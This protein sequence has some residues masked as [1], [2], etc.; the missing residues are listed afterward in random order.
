MRSWNNSIISLPSIRRR[1]D[2]TAKETVPEAGWRSLRLRLLLWIVI[3]LIPAAILSVLHGLDRV[4]RDVADVHERMI[5]MSSAAASD[6][7]S[8]FLSAEQ[9]LRALANQTEVRDAT[10]ACAKSLS[11]ALRGLAYYTNIVRMD[12]A[13]H[14]L[15]TAAPQ[16]RGRA[17][18]SDRTWWQQ[19][20]RSTAFFITPQIYSPIAKRDVLAGVLPLSSAGGMSDGVLV[21]ALDSSWLDA[22]LH[23]KPV[24]DGAVVALFDRTG[25]MVA[26]NDH[27]EAASLFGARISPNRGAQ[28][29]QPARDRQ[30]HG[31]SYTVA[32]LL[33]DNSYLGFAMPN[34]QL[35]ASTYL[36]VA[37]DLFLPVLM[38]GAA[39]IA[40]WIAADR[41]VTRWIVYLRRIATAYAHGHYG[42]RPNALEKAP[43]EF[44][45][46]GES[47]SGMAE[48]VQD[49]DRRLRE[50]LAQKTLLIRETHHRVKNNLQIVMSLLSLQA[51]QLRDPAAQNALRQAQV[52]VNALALVHRILHEIE[53]L[54][55][56]DLKRLIQDL[57]RQIHEGFG[58]E[59]RDLKLELDLASL[60]V[61]GD[62]AVPITLFTVE[63]LTNA[64]KHAYPVGS[65]GGTIRV[66]LRPAPDRKLRLMV[67]DDGTGV[68]REP[69]GSGIGSRL[70]QAF[71]SQVGGQASVSARDGGGTVVALV[72]PD[73]LSS[74]QAAETVAAV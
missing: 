28:S 32:P 3:A 36:H 67:E 2:L 46:L 20:L 71:A 18:L 66:S 43:E 22:M 19:A 29:V 27:D 68:E 1:K 25:T 4:R 51:G 60:Q 14:I 13:G 63:A 42:I 53:D 39:S 44:R 45:M 5:A 11:E 10:P 56:V 9:V 74:Q 23:T 59:R 61:P 17:D 62:L 6:E 48:A 49:R 69:S 38:L 12:A 33:S 50:A 58:A 35:F 37:T 40:I 47:F 34:G 73:P 24:P 57:A 21:I 16:I 54:G 26:S 8:L 72:F 15:C 65:R 70:I 30:G 55:A 31:W 41:L 64:F 7:E 52:R